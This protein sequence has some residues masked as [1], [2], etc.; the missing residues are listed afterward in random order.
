[1]KRMIALCAALMLIV[2]ILPVPSAH[3]A[4]IQIGIVKGGWL[5]LRETASFSAKTLA[6]YN[7]G[8]QV[9]ILS[10]SGAWYRVQGPDLL[11]GYMYGSYLD[12]KKV[13][14]TGSASSGAVSGTTAYVTSQNGKGVRLRAEASL[15]GEV[16][17][18]YNV[19]TRCTILSAGTYWHYISIGSQ[20][21]YMMAEYLTT[22]SG[23]SSTVTV[24]ST[25]SS[26][27][28]AAYVTSKNG[29]GVNLRETASRTSRS[30]G[31]YP[32]GT[33]IT[34]LGY[35]STWCSVQIAGKTG[36]MMTSYIT[37][38]KPA[39]NAQTTVT[40]IVLN[41][42]TPAVGNTLYATVTPSGAT[43]SYQ[44]IDD[45]GR[46]LSSN[47][48]Y[49]VGA[50]MVGRRLYVK[51]TGYGSYQGTS[52]SSYTTAVQAAAST[53]TNITA[54]RLSNTSPKAG[55]TV[56]ATAVP[57]GAN[58]DYYWYRD[59][60]TLVCTNRSYQTQSSDVGHKLYCVAVGT[61]NATGSAASQ[62]TS[63]VEQTAS[64]QTYRLNTVS[65]NNVN[66]KT[67]DLL[68]AT[69]TPAEA[70]ATYTWYRDDDAVVS[71]NRTYTVQQSDVGH[72]LY[73]WANGTGNTTG[74]A[75]SAFTSP[76][77]GTLVAITGSVSLP[78]GAVVGATLT[79][80]LSLNTNN[81]TY[82]WYQNGVLIG[83]GAT[84]YLTDAMAGSDIRLVVQAAPNSG[85]SGE[86]G[87][88]YCLVQRPSTLA[89][90][91][92]EL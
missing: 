12:V 46:L 66:P 74:S 50:E 35:G 77:Q 31:L 24:P 26:G 65:I 71:T 49:T 29:K 14:S 28:Y 39:A 62:Y 59:D 81:V 15:N 22:S 76:V 16:I 7:T 67:G 11:V 51:V 38:Q 52:S 56:T 61:G 73:C 53:V 78:N 45:T 32:V 79:P 75:T 36:Y 63:A 5:R 91:I 57:E 21:G 86:V 30:L 68:T 42:Y 87:S 20:K 69:V 18:F 40:G 88:N 60:M 19:G 64:A 23:P 2:N 3:A 10:S 83:T 43:V 37:T 85:C 82:Q 47:S 55:D 33:L 80:T 13:S 8:T 92:T 25:P 54:V 70:T 41:S 89:P 58:A 90:G 72:Q 27:S 44:W 1:M 84:L 4:D 48:S 9:T 17:G 34:V 6:S